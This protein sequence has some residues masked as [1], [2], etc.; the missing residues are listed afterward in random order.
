MHDSVRIALPA[1]A[2]AA[3]G[4]AGAIGLYHVDLSRISNWL[5]SSALGTEIGRLGA[6]R[7]AKFIGVHAASAWEK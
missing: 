4:A 3:E 6:G 1:G 2:V 7:N 5:V